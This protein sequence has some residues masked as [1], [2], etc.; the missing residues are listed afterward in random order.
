MCIRDR[1][2]PEVFAEPLRAGH[3]A[4]VVSVRVMGAMLLACNGRHHHMF[5]ITLFKSNVLL[6]HSYVT[7]HVSQYTVVCA[8]RHRRHHRMRDGST[9]QPCASP[10][11]SAPMADQPAGGLYV[12]KQLNVMQHVHYMNE[13]DTGDRRTSSRTRR[14]LR[15]GRLD[16]GS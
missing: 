5:G 9:L 8:P 11:F 10:Y 13:Y 3:V 16:A 15:A 2:E 6:A 4:A 1:T 7:T 14:I 12:L